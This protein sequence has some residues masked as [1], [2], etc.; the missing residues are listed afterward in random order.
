MWFFGM[1]FGLV[2]I[3]GLEFDVQGKTSCPRFVVRYNLL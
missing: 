3:L 2:F 1:R